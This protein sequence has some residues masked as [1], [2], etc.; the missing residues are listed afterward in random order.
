MY[1]LLLKKIL[2]I[3]KGA[4]YAERGIFGLGYRPRSTS[5]VSIFKL[6]KKVTRQKSLEKF[7]KSSHTL[8][9]S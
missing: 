4:K 6:G 8:N 1:L 7:E 3:K 2:L 9:W 5:V